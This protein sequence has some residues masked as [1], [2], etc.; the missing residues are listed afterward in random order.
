M[1]E[2]FAM[3]SKKNIKEYSVSEFT[4]DWW[5]VWSMWILRK[6]SVSQYYIIASYIIASNTEQNLLEIKLVLLPMIIKLSAISVYG[7]NELARLVLK[8]EQHR[9][10]GPISLTI[11]P[12][13]FKC[14][15][16]FILLSS[17]Y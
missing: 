13:H 12:S 8:S 15:G 5:T 16:N 1:L 14:D 10:L 4:N 2:I 6:P 11:F 7:W 3:S 9:E 17:K